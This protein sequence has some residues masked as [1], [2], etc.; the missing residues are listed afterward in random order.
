LH[1]DNPLLPH[2][3]LL[4]ARLGRILRQQ[5]RGARFF[6][7]GRPRGRSRLPCSS[8]VRHELSSRCIRRYAGLPT[9]C[10]RAANT[11]QFCEVRWC[12]FAQ[13]GCDVELWSTHA[14]LMSA[15]SFWAAALRSESG[16]CVRSVQQQARL[17]G[18][19]LS[20][21]QCMRPCRC[22]GGGVWAGGVWTGEVMR[23]CPARHSR[24]GYVGIPSRSR[25]RVGL[26]HC[27]PGPQPLR[28]CRV[29]AVDRR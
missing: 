9:K 20:G 21:T 13:P 1:S 23:R 2:I 16:A 27:K 14:C 28:L 26:L 8:Q 17:A 25:R 29:H 24:R 12:C 11:E 4:Y 7:P 5:Q 19:V 10:Q 18:K 6:T 15:V 3:H 22:V